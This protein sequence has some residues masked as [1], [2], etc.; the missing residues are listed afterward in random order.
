MPST[1]IQRK[2]KTTS[3]G[4]VMY[5]KSNSNSTTIAVIPKDTT[6]V[7][8]KEENSY[9]YVQF[10]RERGWISKSK[11]KI[12]SSE[13]GGGSTST[14]DPEGEET[15]D[16]SNSQELTEEEREELYKEYSNYFDG[17]DFSNSEKI[18]LKNMNQVMGMPYQFMKSVDPK[19]DD[20]DFFGMKY[21]DR[22]VTKTP[23]LLITPGKVDF[24]PDNKKKET[25]G[26]ISTL[27][28]QKYG[29]ESAEVSNLLS[30]SGRY[31]AFAFDYTKYFKFVNNM[32][33]SC[34]IFLGIDDCSVN[35]GGASGKLKSL[36]WQKAME[37]DFGNYFSSSECMAFYIDS[38]N[39]VTDTFNNTT[40]ESQLASK[41][42]SFSDVGKEIAFLLGGQAGVEFEMFSQI[43]VDNLTKSVEEIAN[44]YLNG[45]KLFIDLGNQFSTVAAGGK[46][47]FPEI[48]DDSTFTRSFDINIKLRTPDCD[49]LSWY[50]NIC[51]PLCHLIGLVAP[52]RE[53]EMGYFSPFLVRAF[54]K[55]LFNVDMGIITDM[56]FT[57]GSE[58]AWSIDGLPTVVDVSLTIKDL[59]QFVLTITDKDD[60]FMADTTLMDY[61][62]NMCG[63][64]IN[65]PDI[66]RTFEIYAMLKTTK[67]TDFPNRAWSKLNQS[68]SNLAMNAY[69]GIMNILP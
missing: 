53:A 22:I 24:M 62:A 44:K 45:N 43:E 5:E 6:L 18:L 4:V 32:C 21:L 25:A 33:R 66:M 15:T 31:Y 23:L 34:A 55:G 19:S 41:V 68:F 54:Y 2:I 40:T 3:N 65:K 46:L 35:I 10:Q 13:D 30:S 11:T 56:T 39:Q 28:S 8:L 26:I 59:Y 64:N 63:I 50:L 61:M 57:K 7:A 29:T 42:N 9:Y 60:W 38:V 36:D 51:V 47:I 27:A 52:L 1:T 16:S 58:G 17:Y 14:V 37:N 69:Q 12:I 20:N 67:F 49:M 48:W